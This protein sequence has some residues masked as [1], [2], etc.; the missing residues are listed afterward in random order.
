MPQ[1]SPT[2]S[3]DVGLSRR[4]KDGPLE[5][6]STSHGN[7]LQ[8]RALGVEHP[9]T[10]SKLANSKNVEGGQTHTLKDVACGEI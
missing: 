4:M 2:S 7:I 6:C 1:T 5:L 8:K 3:R 10:S 9:P